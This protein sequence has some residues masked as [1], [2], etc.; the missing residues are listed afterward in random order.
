MTVSPTA[1]L[2]ATV[3][4]ASVKL[5][6]LP[7]VSTAALVWGGGLRALAPPGDDVYALLLLVEAAVPAAVTLLV[8]CGRVYPDT[9]PLGRMLLWQ[10]LASLVTLPGWL[11]LFMHLLRL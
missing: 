7:A 11:L 6:L 5:V 3:I 9:R 4:A 1:Q 8:A 10:Y 2:A